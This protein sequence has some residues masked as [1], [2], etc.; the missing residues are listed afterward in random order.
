MD[1]GS[2]TRQTRKADDRGATPPPAPL[3]DGQRLAD[4]AVSLGHGHGLHAILKRGLVH[5]QVA[6][7]PRLLQR[8]ST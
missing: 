3:R 7:A 2:K 4:G 1:R 5:E 8:L 6:A